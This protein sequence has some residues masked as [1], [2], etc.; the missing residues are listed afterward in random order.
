MKHY[1]FSDVE[2]NNQF[3]SAN[4]YKN[5]NYTFRIE[6]EILHLTHTQDIEDNLYSEFR[7]FALEVLNQQSA[8][9]Q[10][11]NFYEYTSEHELINDQNFLSIR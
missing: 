5:N 10:I 1:Q 3:I 11:I 6:A 4:V 7:E 8:L 9:L 2:I